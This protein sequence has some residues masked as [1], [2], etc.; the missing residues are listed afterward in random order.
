MVY[1]SIRNSFHFALM[2]LGHLQNRQTNNKQYACIKQLSV[3]RPQQNTSTERSQ[4]EGGRATGRDMLWWSME[5]PLEP[6]PS[7]SMHSFARHQLATTNTRDRVRVTTS[8][9]SITA[10]C[11]W[12][13]EGRAM[14][15]ATANWSTYA[16]TT[17][18]GPQVVCDCYL[19]LQYRKGAPI[20]RGAGHNNRQCD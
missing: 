18:P 9:A 1:Y 15:M 5:L 4:H 17:W 20:G 16:T 2:R 7:S 11:R 6:T 14:T 3:C 8:G 10:G 19:G 12:P 13:A